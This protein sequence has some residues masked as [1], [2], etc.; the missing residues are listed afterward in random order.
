MGFSSQKYSVYLEPLQKVKV[1]T[2]TLLDMKFCGISDLKPTK[3]WFFRNF[4]QEKKTCEVNLIGDQ[5]I[6]ILGKKL[7]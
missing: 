7:S 3:K 6:A 5:S 4:P 2:S 1:M